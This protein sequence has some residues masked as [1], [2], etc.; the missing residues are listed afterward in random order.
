MGT[1]LLQQI[2]LYMLSSS[3]NFYAVKFVATRKKIGGAQGA[4]FQ[5]FYLDAKR[6]Q[7]FYLR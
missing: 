5:L 2:H 1:K 3:F 4:N 6:K 7:P